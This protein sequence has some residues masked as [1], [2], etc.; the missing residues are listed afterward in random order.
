M[1]QLSV[2]QIVNEIVW[3]KAHPR[4]N[5]YPLGLGIYVFLAFSYLIKELGFGHFG[6]FI[7]V[8]LKQE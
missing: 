8:M 1:F 4:K 3:I 6:K 5:I 7:Q 2:Y